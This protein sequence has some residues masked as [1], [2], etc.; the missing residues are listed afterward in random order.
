VRQAGLPSTDFATFEAKL[1]SAATGYKDLS[2][3]TVV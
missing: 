2:D 1:K 3:V